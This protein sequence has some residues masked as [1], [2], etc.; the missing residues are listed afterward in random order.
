[1]GACSAEPLEKAAA[2]VSI[3]VTTVKY[4]NETTAVWAQMCSPPS[5]VGFIVTPTRG[6]L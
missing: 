3:N 4:D 5:C 6:E 2:S 1:M